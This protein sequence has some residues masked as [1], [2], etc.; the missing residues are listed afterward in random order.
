[1]T[2]LHPG[3]EA[4]NSEFMDAVK[5]G[6]EERFVNL[7]A[8]DAILLLPGRDPL[9]GREGART[10]F[11]SFKARDVREIKLTTLEVEAFETTA[12]ERGSFETMGP[13]G[14]VLGKGKY[15]VIWKRVADRWKLYRDIVNA[16]A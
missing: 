12:W 11:A 14:A 2:S 16:S 7:Y 1:M 10:F 15:I 6:D 9:A 4:A 5:A 13:A 8:D 3:I